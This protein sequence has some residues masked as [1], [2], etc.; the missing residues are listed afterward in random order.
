MADFLRYWLAW[1]SVERIAHTPWGWPL[2][3]SLHFIGLIL[4]IGAIGMFD[5]RLLGFA[6]GL[7]VAPLRKLLP[8]G[9]FGFILCVMGGLL[10]VLGLRANIQVNAYDVILTDPWL[11][12]K[13][14][15][16]ALVGINLLVFYVSGMS[17][18]I[19]HLGPDEDAPPFAKAIAGASLFLWLG[20]IYWGRLIPWGLG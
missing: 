2:A 6:K 15:F 16:M 20:I 11:Q 14:V 5:L 12:L 4:L 1:P 8:W 9:V 3:E 13:L 7:P 19:D 17:R 10:F 18:A